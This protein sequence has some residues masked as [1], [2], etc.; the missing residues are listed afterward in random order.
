MK[1]RDSIL[2]VLLGLLLS[3]L[4]YGSYFY[5]L[6]RKELQVLLERQE[7]LESLKFLAVPG[8]AY[9]NDLGP[10]FVLKSALFYLVLLGLLLAVAQLFSLCLKRPWHRVAFFLLV[11]A[12]LI[13]CTR[14]DR[15]ALSF[16]FITALS[17]GAFFFITLNVR[18][19]ASWF[20]LGVLLL[21]GAVLSSSLVLAAGER[22]F[23]KTRDRLLFDSLIGNQVVSYYYTYSPLAAAVISPAS[24]IYEGL[25]FQEGFEPPFRHLGGG[26]V[27]SGSPSVERKA[28]YRVERR[29]NGHEMVNR[30]GDRET[31]PE[32]SEKAIRHTASSLFSMNGFKLLNQVSL[33]AFP[34]G[35]L[36]LPFFPLRMITKRRG[37]FLVMSLTIVIG[38]MIGIGGISLV[39]AS[40]PASPDAG[41][42]EDL[43]S[44]LGLAYDLYDR[45]DVPA[46]LVPT[47]RGFTRSDSTATRYWGAKLLGY[48]PK[49]SGHDQRLISLLE[50]RSPNVRYA[51]GLSLYRRLGK[52][53]FERLLP[54]L[55]KDPNWYVRCIL[56]SAFL[57][58][59]TIPHR[60]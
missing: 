25:V 51:A 47:V 10:F 41:A 24:G 38:L 20:D 1:K 3:L 17:F 27:L 58:S 7:A 2:S 19:H 40:R 42:P 49:D 12:G 26:L 57:R 45:R 32:L 33:Y 50:D 21:L 15:V 4:L 54:R 43:D 16:P 11:L 22:F 55:L 44:A 18:I 31:L 9:L 14:A 6:V 60:M 29:D 52:D 39:G 56:F 13:A 37:P 8:T 23:I 35:L 34:A 36:M 28:D 30:Y 59:G 48:V 46:E 53:S 5:N